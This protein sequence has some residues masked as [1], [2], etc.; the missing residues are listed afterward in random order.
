MLDPVP[1][2][3]ATMFLCFN[4]AVS[5]A[6]TGP[7]KSGMK[8]TSKPMLARTKKNPTRVTIFGAIHMGRIL[9]KAFH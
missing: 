4:H 1:S 9:T 6:P 8:M 7:T 5:S 2:R 3:S